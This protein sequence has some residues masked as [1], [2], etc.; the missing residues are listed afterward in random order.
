MAVLSK[1][2]RLTYRITYGKMARETSI[3]D[4]NNKKMT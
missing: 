2:P 3:E 1:T 4:D